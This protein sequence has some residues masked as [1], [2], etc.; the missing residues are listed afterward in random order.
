MRDTT[1]NQ[2]TGDRIQE[3]GE[4][5]Q[6]TEDSMQKEQGKSKKAKSSR[7]CYLLNTKRYTQYEIRTMNDAVDFFEKIYGFTLTF[8]P[9][10]LG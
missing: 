9:L 2:N 4:R 8:C 3:T 6:E 10:S 7:N 1:R 5:I